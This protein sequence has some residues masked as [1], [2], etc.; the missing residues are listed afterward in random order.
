MR[1]LERLFQA[2]RTGGLADACMSNVAGVPS[3][4]LG[5]PV[6]R[7]LVIALPPFQPFQAHRTDPRKFTITKRSEVQLKPNY[8]HVAKVG[9]CLLILNGFQGS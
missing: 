8:L 1:A 2:G 3:L 4:A 7:D 6:Y 5:V 9:S